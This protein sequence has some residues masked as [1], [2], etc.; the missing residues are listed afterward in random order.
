[1]STRTENGALAH[2]TTGSD[3]VD[4]YFQS[5]RECDPINFECMLAAAFEE[6][7]LATTRL[8]FNLRDVRGGK[9]ERKL[10]DMA[11]TWYAD[12]AIEWID[13][14]MEHIYEYGRWDDYFRGV[15]MTNPHLRQL[16]V[17]L[18]ASQLLSDE[19]VVHSADDD[20][21][22]PISLL[23]KWIPREGKKLDRESRCDGSNIVYEIADTLFPNIGNVGGKY[24]Q[25]RNLVSR[26]NAYLGTVETHM[27]ANQWSNIEY[28]TVP[29]QAIQRY[30]KAF[31]LNDVQRYSEWI[32]GLSS[33]TS[34]INAG[35]LHPHQCIMI[36]HTPEAIAQWK[37]I[38]QKMIRGGM[39]TNALCV[40]DVSGSMAGIPMDVAVALGLLLSTT[41][42]GAWARQLIT[43]SSRPEC[44]EVT[45]GSFTEQVNQV[46][47]MPWGMNTDFTAVLD[48]ILK[49]AID[50]N[51]PTD[52][53]P[54]QIYVF[55]DMQFDKCV[56]NGD[57]THFQAAR[58]K[59][60]E[61]GY[62]LPTFVFWNLRATPNK[63]FP[64]MSSMDNVLVASG[65]SQS[66]FNNL[67]MCKEITPLGM[68][69]SLAN[70]DR[71]SAITA[72]IEDDLHS[73]PVVSRSTGWFGRWLG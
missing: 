71:Y 47:S 18:A 21:H 52:E 30:R 13:T 14:N 11:M 1:M 31:Y 59:F 33:G 51:I 36:S 43:F 40:V 3:L 45:T 6:D 16:V 26:L 66:M 69:M 38:C 23:A 42:T 39:H 58:I 5:V 19:I 70:S 61:A 4:F 15:W 10:F 27:C 32:A 57:A 55:S 35:T 9:G 67:L 60:T 22:P 8:V 7:P 63:G 12:N 17:K 34:K 41:Q 62:Q 37:E 24:K 53:M 54:E 48:L 2:A 28:N 72:P 50:Q 20:N 64:V 56:E 46:K 49:R 68:V 44:V 29:S 73:P 25:Y 65:F